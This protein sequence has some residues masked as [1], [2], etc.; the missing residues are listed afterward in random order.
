MK[1]LILL[2]I[3]LIISFY[4]FCTYKEGNRTK[5][6][7][8]RRDRAP[9]RPTQER[10]RRVREERERRTRR[11]FVMY[12]EEIPN[13]IHYLF[14]QNKINTFKFKEIK[15]YFKHRDDMNN[16]P[17][18]SKCHYTF[19]DPQIENVYEY[20][21][22]DPYINKGKTFNYTKYDT[23]W[24]LSPYYKKYMYCMPRD[25]GYPSCSMLSCNKYNIQKHRFKMFDVVNSN[26]LKIKNETSKSLKKTRVS[27]ETAQKNDQKNNFN[28]L[29][30]LKDNIILL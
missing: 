12:N 26:R 15:D 3:L 30:I 7:R 19:E 9:T 25:K 13:E 5:R 21:L 1:K 8:G 14:K 18:D 4:K 29:K 11:S 27:N 20:D 22:D 23:D 28:Y 16:I 17:L 6:R 10:D 24:L 2:I